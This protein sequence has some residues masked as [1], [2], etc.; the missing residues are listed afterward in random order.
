MVLDSN[1]IISNR[2]DEHID[3]ALKKD[4]ESKIETWFDCIHLIHT[5]LPENDLKEVSIEAYLL[6]KK[7]NAPILIE[8]MTGGTKRGAEINEKLAIIA[9]QFNIPMMVGSQRVAIEDPALEWTFRIAR[10]VSPDIFLIGNIGAAQLVEYNIKKIVKA[11]DM[12]DADALAI[13]LNPLQESVQP[14]GDSNFKGIMKRIE[15]IASEI[16]VPIVVKETGAGISREVAIALMETGIKAIDVAGLG[17]TSWSAIEVFRAKKAGDIKKAHLGMK[18]RDWGIPT[19]ASVI[20]VKSVVGDSIE[21]IASGGIRDGIDV[22]KAISIGADFAGL[23][24]PILMALNEGLEK[25][26][27]FLERIFYEIRNVVFLTGSKNLS[28]LKEKPVIVFPPL[29]YWLKSRKINF[30]GL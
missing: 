23:A 21:V 20:E 22:S 4:V 26:I 9:S 2:K 30:K 6:G 13:H 24:R 5:A 12:I 11:I 10:D 17:G 1:D 8:G 3:I 19:A 15:Y 29:R 7:F 25:L 16:D 28:E 27:E 14:E 18:F